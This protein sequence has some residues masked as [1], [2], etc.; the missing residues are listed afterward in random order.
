M[1]IAAGDDDDLEMDRA[2]AQNGHVDA[3]FQ[4]PGAKAKEKETWEK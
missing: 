4:V 3:R 1:A 2:K